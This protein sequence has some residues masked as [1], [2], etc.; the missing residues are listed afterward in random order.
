VVKRRADALSSAFW[1]LVFLV[2][3]PWALVRFVGRPFPA[4]LPTWAELRF[5][6]DQTGLSGLS[7]R[8]VVDIFAIL[9]WALW[10]VLLWVVLAEIVRAI[11]RIRMPQMRLAAPPRGILAGLIGAVVVAVTTAASRGATPAPATTP[12][13]ATAPHHLGTLPAGLTGTPEPTTAQAASA[14][15]PTR[16][17]PK[18]ATTPSAAQ[19]SEVAAQVPALPPGTGVLLTPECGYVHTVKDGETLWSIAKM[20]Y[21]SGTRWPEIWHLNEGRFWPTVSGYHHFTNPDLIYP[22]WT[23]NLP[24]SAAPPAG[25]AKVHPDPASPRNPDPGSQS[26]A[27]PAH[28]VPAPTSSPTPGP[29]ASAT[30]SPSATS[31]PLAMPG[32]MVS[33]TPSATATPG[34]PVAAGSPPVPAPALHDQTPPAAPTPGADPGGVS[35][36][37]GSWTPWA[38]AFALSAAAALV[39]LQR[40]R[41]YTPGDSHELPALPEAVVALQRA[42][43][44]NPGYVQLAVQAEPSAAVPPAAPVPPG[45]VGLV[46]DGAPAAARAALAEILASGGPGD[47]DARGEVIID[48]ATLTTLIGSDTAAFRPWPRL[49]V[50][51]DIDHALTM[52]E[53]RLLHRSRILDEHDLT[54]LDTLRQRVP[55]EEALPPVLLITHTPPPGA[56]MRAKACMGLGGGLDV[57]GLFLGEWDHGPT[58]DVDASG[59]TQLIA[60]TPAMPLPTR[61]AVLQPAAATAIMLTLHEAHTGE[62]PATALPASPPGPS[63][64]PQADQPPHGQGA[65]REAL[66]PPIAPSAAKARLRVLGEPGI[67]N[68]TRPGRA[69]RTKARELAVYLACHPDGAPTREIGEYLEPDAKLSQADERVHTNASNLR[70]VFGRAAGPIKYGYVV[71][72]MGLY[73]LDPARIAVDLWDLR[74]LL[75]HAALASG[76]RRRDLLQQACNLCRGP[77]AQGHNY[78][79]IEPHRETA[80]RLTTEAHLLLA[81]DLLPDDPQATSDL[82]DKAI[83][84]DRY[85]E[86]LYRQG[87][88]ARHALHDADG[89]RNLLRALTKALAE[90]DAEPGEDTLELA[91]QLRNSL[92]H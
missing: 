73:R 23:L 12:V 22:D 40:R 4:H 62:P 2:G 33:G 92:E 80:R 63:G 21:G 58:V 89:I 70:H 52:I 74:D 1:L 60:G 20:C 27:A 61:M 54:D 67:D 43:A 28:P 18:G 3:L 56:T 69:L 90:L 13:A 81:D 75:H 29:D 5:V 77:L 86:Q 76:Q 59:H 50:A 16:P 83:R 65:S 79:W 91:R 17:T 9:M 64:Q 85:N 35:L 24:P 53:D 82:L 49:H 42:V 36:P 37:D 34:P 41:R 48:A 51:H 8:G 72:Y 57:T 87:M 38:L 7:R 55:D 30:G 31:P 39:W 11:R 10:A 15:Q 66:D 68:V 25:T 26:P 6:L 47:P 19:H 14:N 45:G 32:P 78:E 44:R 71:K 46:G 84:L 88:H